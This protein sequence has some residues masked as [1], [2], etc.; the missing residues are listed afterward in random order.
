M[1]SIRMRRIRCLGGVLFAFFLALVLAR[2]IP[3]TVFAQ[4][5]AL[6][7]SAPAN[8]G[9]VEQGKYILHK[10]EQPIGEETYQITRDGDSLSAK[11]DFK[12]T[13]RSTPVP[14]TASF[15]SAN[16]LTPRAFEIKGK[17]SRSTDIDEAVEVQTDKIRLRDRDKWTETARPAQLFTIAG[18]APTTMQ[19]LLVRYWAAHGSPAALATLPGSG[20]VKVEPRG[21]DS[22]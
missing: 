21:S 16:D 5:T 19:M 13:D 20:H 22:V 18:Y 9:S 11:I 8:R 15:R 6:P 10:F 7:Q 12:F 2:A 14:L 4:S 3:L 17:N 1:E